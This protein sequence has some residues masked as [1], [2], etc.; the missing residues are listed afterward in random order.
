M[1]GPPDKDEEVWLEGLAVPFIV[2]AI[3][4][5]DAL[6]GGPMDMRFEGGSMDFRTVVRGIVGP[7]VAL[8]DEVFE[9]SCLVG[10]L[11]GDYLALAL[12]N[13]GPPIH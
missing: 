9:P 2:P 12:F 6:R 10:D 13:R 11:I 3:D 1:E 7:G 4:G 5:R 8:P